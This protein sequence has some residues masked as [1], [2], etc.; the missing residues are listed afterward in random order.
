M[1]RL[2]LKPLR[3]LR[4]LER[5][6]GFEPS[7][8]TLARLC[9]T[10]ELHPRSAAPE[11]RC[12][13]PHVP[14]PKPFCKGC[15]IAGSAPRSAPRLRAA[16]RRRGRAAR[17]RLLPEPSACPPR[18]PTSSR[19]SSASASRRGPIEHAPVFTVAQSQAIKQEIPGGHSKN[20]FLKDKK[21][22]LF[23][24]VAEAGPASTSSG[25]TRRSAP[26]GACPSAPP[27]SCARSSASSPAR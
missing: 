10:P 14:D 16:L 7:T 22:R 3:L 15:A 25:C 21:G 11:R 24:V 18:P 20:L 12:E 26:P 6:K 27:S 4:S 5:A 23:L 9:S 19:S 17:S 1:P 8:P 2:P 13:A